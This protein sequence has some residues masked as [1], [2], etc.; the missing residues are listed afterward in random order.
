VLTN[1]AHKKPLL[2]QYNDGEVYSVVRTI[3][4]MLPGKENELFC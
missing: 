3:K 2:S 1:F 4:Q